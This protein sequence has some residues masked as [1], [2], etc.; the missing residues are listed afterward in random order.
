M[1]SHQ[2]V[3]RHGCSV[4]ICGLFIIQITF[5]FLSIYL[6]IR[7][8]FV[9]VFRVMAIFFVIYYFSNK[10][11]ITLTMCPVVMSKDCFDVFIHVVCLVLVDIALGS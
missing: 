7:S 5:G 9:C 10:T 4:Y 2:L 11:F 1:D 3:C 8:I 6:H